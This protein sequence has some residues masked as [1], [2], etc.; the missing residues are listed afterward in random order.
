[1][2]YTDTSYPAYQVVYVTTDDAYTLYYQPS[3][4]VPMDTFDTVEE[5]WQYAEM[6]ETHV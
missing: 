2:H 6:L 4:P 5:C 1:M 3:Y